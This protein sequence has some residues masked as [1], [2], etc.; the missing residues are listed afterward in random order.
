MTE[1]KYFKNFFLDDYPVTYTED[2]AND[3]A[4]KVEIGKNYLL[5]L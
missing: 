3:N 2:D 4:L 1:D 5:I